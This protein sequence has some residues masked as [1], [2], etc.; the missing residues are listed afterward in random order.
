MD[1]DERMNDFNEHGDD[2]DKLNAAQMY[3]LG[4]YTRF[5]KQFPWY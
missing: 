3:L 4:R 5:E 2:V 1:D